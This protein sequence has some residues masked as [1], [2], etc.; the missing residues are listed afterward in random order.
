[1]LAGDDGSP[2][3]VR[4]TEI[5]NDIVD[6]TPLGDIPVLALEAPSPTLSGAPI[7]PSGPAE[8]DRG[9]LSVAKR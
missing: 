2:V 6:P 7:E 1:M 4:I 3:A 5:V 9:E 8:P